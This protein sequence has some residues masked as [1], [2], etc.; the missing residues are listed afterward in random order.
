MEKPKNSVLFEAFLKAL[1]NVAG[2]RTSSNFADEAIGST[3]KTLENRFNFMKFVTV[4]KSNVPE[5][6][7][8]IHVS[9]DI[10]SI[11]PELL[12]KAIEALIR[13]V[14]NDLSE[15]AGLYF[16]NELKD[17]AGE[18]ITRMISDF[19]VDLDQVQLEQ[20][21]AFRRRERKKVISETVTGGKLDGK[22]PDNLLGYTWNN[23]SHWKH[24]PGSRYCTLYDKEGRVLDRLN[25]DRI[26]QNYVERLSGYMNVDE[27]TIQKE[28]MVYEKEYELLKLL[29]ERDMDAENAMHALKISREE[30]N[31]MISRLSQ[32]EMLQYVDFNTVE[33]TETGIG[34]LAKKEEKKK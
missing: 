22:K 5:E 9:S 10:D 32:M 23:V 3:I 2:R 31:S 15:E 4:S 12:G 8:A 33:L 7:Y 21:Y 26:I 13:V 25:L 19:E 18:E 14:Y 27:R 28:S 16:V 6:G 1:Y 30:L 11:R 29:L 20:H 34:L 24:E 17:Q